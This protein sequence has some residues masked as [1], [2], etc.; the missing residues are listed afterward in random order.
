MK[1]KKALE[2][3]RNI[4]VIRD[5]ALGDFIVRK[6]CLVFTRDT[7]KI[8]PVRRIPHGA[9]IPLKKISNGIYLL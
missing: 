3:V 8:N 7:L 1:R 9:F 4:L 5:G 2:Q 6:M